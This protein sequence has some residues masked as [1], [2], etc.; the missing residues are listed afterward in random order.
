MSGGHSEGGSK[1]MRESRRVRPGVDALRLCERGHA[2]L[3]GGLQHHKQPGDRP[4]LSTAQHRDWARVLGRLQL[5]L[6]GRRERS[7]Q[8][9]VD[10]GC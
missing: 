10:G 5:S 9:P 3:L 1:A 4:S 6:A 7:R 2:P 8:V